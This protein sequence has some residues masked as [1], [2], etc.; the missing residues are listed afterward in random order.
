MADEYNNPIGYDV[1]PWQYRVSPEVLAGQDQNANFAKE[2][3][4]GLIAGQQGYNQAQI[5]QYDIQKHKMAV[6]DRPQF[7]QNKNTGN[8]NP[9]LNQVG[10]QQTIPINADVM[11]VSTSAQ[12]GHYF[13]FDPKTG[14]E[15]MTDIET[16]SKENKPLKEG[17]TPSNILT[18]EDIKTIVKARTSGKMTSKGIEGFRNNRTG[19]GPVNWAKINKA[20]IA[21]GWNEREYEKRYAYDQD[22]NNQQLKTSF[23]NAHA[24]GETLKSIAKMYKQSNYKDW[25]SFLN[26]IKDR[27]GNTLATKYKAA[28]LGYTDSVSLALGPA[29][30]AGTNERI[31]LAR[32]TTDKNWSPDQIVDA[33]EEN[34]QLIENR[35]TSMNKSGVEE[36][37][38][39]FNKESETENTIKIGSA[40]QELLKQE[41]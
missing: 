37:L 36:Y 14:Q 4:G 17:T 8:I 5:Q 30:S 32:G 16:G 18:D 27:T 15:G 38:K 13:T 34:E 35:E 6:A 22:L 31:E 33:I 28:Q 3:A 26:N 7:T 10:E 9:V 20:L 1:R 12:G 19:S 25:N 41:K 40:L 39:S 21:A 29:R 2:L 24:D 11:G 23:L